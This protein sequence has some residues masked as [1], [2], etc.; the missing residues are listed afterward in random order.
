M[1]EVYAPFIINRTIRN[2]TFYV[3]EG[4]NFVRKKSSLTRRKVLYS[5]RFERTRENATLM[6]QA[7]KIGSFIYN[8]LPA[9][10]RQSWMYRSFTGEAYKLLKRK[11]DELEIRQLLLD[12]YVNEVAEK[13]RRALP[14]L[15]EP[16]IT[17]RT[18]RKQDT[19]WWESKTRNSIQ[20][21]ARI[22]QRERNS[23]LLGEASKIA[24]ELYNELPAKSR[25]RSQYQKLTGLSMK[26]LKDQE[27]DWRRTDEHAQSSTK[28]QSKKN[29]LGYV[30][31]QKGYFVFVSPI[32]K[33]QCK[34]G[35]APCPSSE[36][37]EIAFNLSGNT[38]SILPKNTHQLRGSA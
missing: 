36:K 17:K 6:G 13:Q 5:P 30:N 32:S 16:I 35:A 33:R 10:W 31:Y 24:A 9:H 38:S 11:K 34:H 21:K 1:A 18:N 22:Q 19:T 3:M 23:G 7:S 14:S 8:S 4:R 12:Q 15:P 25:N 26:W 2:L 28:G 27:E 29:K 20:R 37:L